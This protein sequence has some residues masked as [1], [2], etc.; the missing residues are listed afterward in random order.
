MYSP[1]PGTPGADM[2]DHV[3]PDVAAERLQR[4]QALLNKQQHE[5]NMSKVG[6]DMKVLI[7]KPG[8]FENQL[9]GRSPWLQSVVIED[10]EGKLNIGDITSV[11]IHDAGPNSLN[12][13]LL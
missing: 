2:K 10:V 9:I 1:R 3:E 4:L 7:E 6:T 11:H 8:K 12:G 13:T 5:F